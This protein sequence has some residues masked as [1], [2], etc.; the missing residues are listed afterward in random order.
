MCKWTDFQGHEERVRAVLEHSSSNMTTLED[1]MAKRHMRTGHEWR[2]PVR[3][4]RHFRWIHKEGVVKHAPL[5][6]V[7][8]R[9]H[10]PAC[11]ELAGSLNFVERDVGA[12]GPHTVFQWCNP[13]MEPICPMLTSMGFDVSRKWEALI[14][15][16]SPSAQDVF[17]CEPGSRIHLDSDALRWTILIPLIVDCEGGELLVANTRSN[18]FHVFRQSQKGKDMI[19][20]GRA[21]TFKLQPGDFL[22]ICPE[23]EHQVATLKS[24]IRVMLVATWFK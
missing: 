4:T 1:I 2:A 10:L 16:Y 5:N 18:L 23:V 22:Q 6:D 19:D 13:Y 11:V 17:D 20:R 24:G 3:R 21:Y 8:V 12:L 7:C 9:E 15:V 14:I